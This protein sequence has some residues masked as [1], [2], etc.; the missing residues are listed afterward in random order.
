[1]PQHARMTR[2]ASAALSQAES[3]RSPITE[4][5]GLGS[6]LS[7]KFIFHLRSTQTLRPLLMLM[8]PQSQ[9][10]SPSPESTTGQSWSPSRKSGTTSKA[11]NARSKSLVQSVAD[12]AFADKR[13]QAM[14]IG[15]TTLPEDVREMY[16]RLN[17]LSVGEAILPTL[18]KVSTL[19]GRV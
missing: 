1:M 2:A 8:P 17:A 4:Q 15:N 10:P 6:S 12:L 7:T 9:D 18:I 3:S 14:D 19:S 11:S 16:K 5:H 13:I